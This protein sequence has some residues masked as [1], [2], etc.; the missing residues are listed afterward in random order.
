MG[1]ISLYINEHG[2][3]STDTSSG[4]CSGKATAHFKAIAHVL[5]NLQSRK[6]TINESGAVAGITVG[7]G[8]RRIRRKPA[9]APFCPPQIPHKPNMESNLCSRG[10]KPATNSMSYGMAQSIGQEFPW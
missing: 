7:K 2:N 9:P 10:G 5:P 4:W 1:K 3:L 6:M 8:K